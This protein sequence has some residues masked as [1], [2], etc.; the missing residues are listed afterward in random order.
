MTNNRNVLELSAQKEVLATLMGRFGD[1]MDRHPAIAWSDIETKL[2]AATTKLWSLN[3]MELTGGEPD[4]VG[5][6]GSTGEYLFVDCSKQSPTG[7]RNLCYDDAALQSRKANKPGGSAMGV[8]AD[9]GIEL[10]TEDQYRELQ[11]LGAFD[12]TTSSWV[13]TPEGVRARGGALFCDR[14]YDAV[15][16]YHNG[17]ESYYAARGFRGMLRV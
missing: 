7:R 4:V 14:R 2:A 17:A 1:N 12:T 16:T 9:M 10:L 8:A 15:F 13:V 3:E 11:K 5:R 6:D